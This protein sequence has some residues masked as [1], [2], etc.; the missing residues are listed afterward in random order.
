MEGHGGGRKGTAR[1]PAA[2]GRAPRQRK[3]ARERQVLSEPRPL[4]V[5]I[6][7][8]K[9]AGT[10]FRRILRANVPRGA[11]NNAGNVFKGRGGVDPAVLTQLH[12]SVPMLARDL[13]VLTGHIPFGI[14]ASLPDDTRY[15]TFLR[16]PIDRTLSHYHRIM[17]VRKRDPLPEGTTLEQILSE[18]IYL[19]DNLQTRMLSDHP[20]PFD[21]VTE[22]ML[23]QAK[24]NLENAFAA[25]GLVERFDESLVF[26]QREL[27]LQSVLYVPS[28]VADRPPKTEVPEEHLRA[29]ERYNEHDLELYRFAAELFERRVQEQDASFTIDLAALKK[30]LS[31][32]TE[33]EAPDTPLPSALDRRELWGMVVDRQ[34]AQLVRDQGLLRLLDEANATLADLNRRVERLEAKISGQGRKRA[35]PVGRGLK[36][37]GRIRRRR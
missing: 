30:A 12:A 24:A 6:H 36:A 9:T 23:E 5:F 4:T 10:T 16:D 29:A 28:Q 15:V 17:E 19:H 27:E 33:Q 3:R 35:G 34:A 14:R 7:I 25:I 11:I 20:A 37:F 13:Y 22:E 18:G 8:P 26:F 2:G 31:A 32:G 1:V 21:D